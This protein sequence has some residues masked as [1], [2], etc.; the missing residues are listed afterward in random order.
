MPQ[1][2]ARAS[3][4]A[5]LN[6]AHNMH[7]L[8]NPSTEVIATHCNHP[9]NRSSSVVLVEVPGFGATDYGVL[10]EIQ[11]VQAWMTRHLKN[12]Q[13]AGVIYLHRISE[14]RWSQSTA[15]SL[16]VIQQL[17]GLDSM[18]HFVVAT[19]MWSEVRTEIAESRE[20][21]IK[22]GVVRDIIERG[23]KMARFYDSSE[24]AWDIIDHF[25]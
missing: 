18:Q 14:N 10:E 25:L 22:E 2:I 23:G 13:L 17:F 21:S 5:N 19:T 12:G 8:H 9:T 15:N 1:F 4:G 11:K 16:F 3:D 20:Q 7:G 6:T 24:S